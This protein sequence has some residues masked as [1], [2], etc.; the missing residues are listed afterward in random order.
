MQQD[1][2]PYTWTIWLI[3]GMSA[4][5]MTR[6][7]F[8]LILLLLAAT[9]L[10]ISILRRT[11]RQDADL[12][13]SRPLA[14]QTVVRLALVLWGLTLLFNAVTV[15]AGA[16][17]LFSLPEQWPLV[18][19]PVTLESITFGFITGLS[20]VLLILLFAIYNS[21]LGPSIILRMTPG[22]A[23][24][25]G[26]A[27]SIAIAF[28]PQTVIA[29]S[30]I[31]EAQR[32]RGHKLK[33]LRDVQP[34]F[35]SLLTYGLDRAIQ[36]AESMDA[37]GFGGQ[38]RQLSGREKSLIRISAILGLLLLL[39]GLALKATSPL[40]PEI[41]LGILGMLISGIAALGFSL[42]RQGRHLPRSHYR[43]WLWRPRDGVVLIASGVLLLT[44]ILSAWWR[45]QA[46]FYHPYPPY[47]YTPPLNP[48]LSLIFILPILPALLLP[49]M[50]KQ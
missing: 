45:P 3:A 12:A 47:P 38:A 23:Y 1:F 26:V 22:F 35:I 14:W 49:P 40:R 20:F 15:H 33:G 16:H 39:A 30:E 7:P 24:Q 8:Y 32:L 37:R 28:I 42:W 6:N 13:H 9:F 31:R 29:W 4:A 41:G 5:L 11:A 46:F 2:H 50:E 18:G 21:V 17:A 10:Y 19:G 48:L 27:L 36:L 25:A 43:R 44:L 34:L